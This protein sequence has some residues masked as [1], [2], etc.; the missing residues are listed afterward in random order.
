MLAACTPYELN[1]YNITGNLYF[2][3]GKFNGTANM[4]D[5][6]CAN[7]TF[8]GDYESDPNGS[9]YDVAVEGILCHE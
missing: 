4:C 7:M 3:A 8:S 6:D 2:S 5:Y 9:C 1:G